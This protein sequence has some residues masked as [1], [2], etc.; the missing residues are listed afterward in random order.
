MPDFHK[1]N[2]GTAL[3]RIRK[4]TKAEI[5]SQSLEDLPPGWDG[6]IS[7]G[8]PIN[9]PQRGQKPCSI[10]T[11]VPHLGHCIGDYNR[12]IHR[13]QQENQQQKRTHPLVRPP[14]KFSHSLL[15]HGKAHLH[16]CNFNHIALIQL[17]AMGNFG[18]VHLDWGLSVLG[19]DEV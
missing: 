11:S 17:L 19:R 13:F 14:Q 6:C 7:P 10:R 3:T 9:T 8:R 4:N 15:L 18:P 16:P 12:S 1:I 5:S 2:T